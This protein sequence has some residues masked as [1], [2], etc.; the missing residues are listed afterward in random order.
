[1]FFAPRDISFHCCGGLDERQLPDGLVALLTVHT[2]TSSRKGA[3]KVPEHTRQFFI[4]DIFSHF[5]PIYAILCHF[6]P[7][8]A[9]LCHFWPFYATWHGIK[10][11]ML[12]KNQPC[13][14]HSGLFSIF[15]CSYRPVHLHVVCIYHYSTFNIFQ[16]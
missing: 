12:A 11:F 2:L 6:R 14:D 13:L 10:Y 4:I 8:Y 1:M 7:I 5:M 15:V 3:Q 9:N 16:Q